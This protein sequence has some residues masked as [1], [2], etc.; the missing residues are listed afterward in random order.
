[1]AWYRRRA[2][3]AV[4]ALVELLLRWLDRASPKESA[5]QS[6]AIARATAAAPHKEHTPP[7]SHWILPA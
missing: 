5:A 6:N 3:T 4:E 1:M 2:K 7:L